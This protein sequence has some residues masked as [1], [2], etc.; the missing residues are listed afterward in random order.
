[1]V[2]LV[3]Y[4]LAHVPLDFEEQV[5][6]LKDLVVVVREREEVDVLDFFLEVFQVLLW[7]RLHVPISIK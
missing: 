5:V 2:G 7:P 4:P 6:D 3:L 1:M